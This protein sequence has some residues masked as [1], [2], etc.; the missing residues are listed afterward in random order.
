MSRPIQTVTEQI[1]HAIRDD[2]FAQRLRSGEKLTTKSLQERLGV[3]STPIREA[4]ARLEKD[5]LIMVQP[6]VGMRVVSYTRKDVEDIYTLMAEL[7]AIAMRLAFGGSKQ[8]EMLETLRELQTYSIQALM[9]GDLPQWEELS[10]RFH[11]IFYWYADNS[12]LIDVAERTRCQLTVFSHAYQQV[13]TNREEIQR[14]HDT[15]LHCLEAGDVRAAE[16]SLR[17]HFA[18]SRAKALDS[19]QEIHQ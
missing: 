6:N 14:Q 9:R 3:S 16:E 10:D 18:S 2:I 17:L 8:Q 13:D 12:R 5:G 4:L 1:Y 7:D 11:L 15:I 19:W